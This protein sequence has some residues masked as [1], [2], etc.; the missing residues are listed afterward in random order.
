[1]KLKIESN[2][3]VPSEMFPHDWHHVRHHT[4]GSPQ[5]V[6]RAVL[7]VDPLQENLESRN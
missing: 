4:S 2:L 6:Q 5:L 1:M 3:P 7:I